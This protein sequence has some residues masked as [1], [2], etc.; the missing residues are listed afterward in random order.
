MIPVPRILFYYV[1]YCCVFCS[2]V[3]CDVNFPLYIVLV[4]IVASRRAR[5]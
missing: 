1:E 4:C 5:C 2:H 3:W